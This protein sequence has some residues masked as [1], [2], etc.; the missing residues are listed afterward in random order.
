VGCDRPAAVP[1]DLVHDGLDLLGGEPLVV[2]LVVRTSHP[3]GG[4]DLDDIGALSQ[5]SSYADAHLLDGVD[6]LSHAIG[7]V[8]PARRG[9][10]A[11]A[12]GVAQNPDGGVQAGTGQQPGGPGDPEPRWKPAQIAGGGDAGVQSQ[13]HPL[14]RLEAGDRGIL[15]EPRHELA[16]GLNTKM[17]VAVDEAGED[18]SSSTVQH[19]HPP[20]VGWGA[21]GRPGVHDPAR[22]DLDDGSMKRSSPCRVDQRDVLDA[23]R[24]LIAAALHADLVLPGSGAVDL[25]GI[26]RTA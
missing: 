18:R 2:R 9:E 3:T 4:T 10:I 20:Q 14:G 7:R 23:E 13:A 5:E 26:P 11:V 15:Q 21:V 24:L 22:F 17:D 16:C 25:K 1:C 19:L 6:Q 8:E 12:A